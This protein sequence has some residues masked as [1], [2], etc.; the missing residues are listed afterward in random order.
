MEQYL[1][2]GAGGGIG[3]AI[4]VKLAGSGKRFWL[5]GRNADKLN[6]TARQVE[7]L[8]SETRVARCD[9]TEAQ[10]IDALVRLVG[11]EP[12]QALVHNAGIAVVKPFEQ[13]TTAEWEESNAV[14]LTAPFLLTKGLLPNLQAGS[15]IVS[16]LSVAARTPFANWSSYC[17]GK[18]GLD[19]CM[20]SIRE[21]LR[22]R[23][24]R[25]INI[26]PQATATDIWES[27]PGDWPKDKMLSAERVADAVLFALNQPASVLVEDIALGNLGGNL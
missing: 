18:F 8:G 24:I 3:Q 7:Q 5:T 12:L 17:A 16:I 14:N 10:Q 22:P 15:S 21:E 6:E 1:I 9:L 2:T 27:V 13:I 25:V 23:G 4:A 26:Y 20:R 11:R 19:G